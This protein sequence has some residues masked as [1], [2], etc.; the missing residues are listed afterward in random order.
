MQDWVGYDGDRGQ[1]RGDHLHL[2]RSHSPTRSGRPA[3]TV[4]TVR[5]PQKT[6]VGPPGPGSGSGSGGTV[7]PPSP[8]PDDG[9]GIGP[10]LVSAIETT[11]ETIQG[12]A[13]PE[14]GGIGISELAGCGPGYD[15]GP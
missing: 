12:S 2:S 6:P 15:R 9:G 7:P 10:Q 11:I 5:C 1:G 4:Y 13:V 3:R 8:A 14:Q